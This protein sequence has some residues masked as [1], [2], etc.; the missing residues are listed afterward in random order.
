MP[1]VDAYDVRVPKT[2]TLATLKPQD[3]LSSLVARVG[4]YPK[5]AAE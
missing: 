4:V 1:I 3:N 5:V 2:I